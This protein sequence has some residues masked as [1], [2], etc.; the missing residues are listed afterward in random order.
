M[1]LIACFMVLAVMLCVFL[2]FFFV[3]YHSK[4]KLDIISLQVLF[5]VFSITNDFIRQKVSKIIEILMINIL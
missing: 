3:Y 1:G 5:N 2:K 4:E